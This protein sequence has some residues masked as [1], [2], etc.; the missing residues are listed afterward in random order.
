M[1]LIDYPLELHYD[2]AD[3]IS[4]IIAKYEFRIRISITQCIFIVTHELKK[5]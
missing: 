2:K 1:E 4:P 3:I 5:H